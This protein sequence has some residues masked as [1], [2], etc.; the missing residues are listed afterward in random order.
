MLAKSDAFSHLSLSLEFDRIVDASSEAS[1]FSYKEIIKGEIAQPRTAHPRMDRPHGFLC[2]PVGISQ[3]SSTNRVS[4]GLC[5]S[6]PVGF[7]AL[8]IRRGNEISL[9]VFTN[10]S[11]MFVSR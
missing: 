2:A 3:K 7:E 11:K 8:E 5:A 6:H 1:S 9:H 10:F 4:D